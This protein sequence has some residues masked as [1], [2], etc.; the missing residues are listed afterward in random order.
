M[1]ALTTSST[2][3]HDDLL[4]IDVAPLRLLMRMIGGAQLS[5]AIYAVVKLGIPDVCARGP[6]T[7]E[8]LATVCGADAR[9]LGRYLRVLAANRI[10]SE[11][12]KGLYSLTEIGQLLRSDVPGTAAPF[13]ILLPELIEPTADAALYALRTGRSAFVHSHGCGLYEYLAGVPDTEALFAQAMSAR[14]S[15]HHAAVIGAVDWDGVR[16]VVDVGG[17]HGSFLTAI[18]EH[19]PG[20]TGILFDQPHVVA[21]AGPAL[22]EAGVADRVDV[23]PGDFFTAVPP[24]GDLYLVANVLWNWPDDQARGILQRCREA[25]APTARLA[26]CEPVIP[27]GNELHAAKVLDLGN[28]W[29]NGGGTRTPDEWREFLDRAGFELVGITETAVEWSVIEARPATYGGG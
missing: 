21:G 29:L 25:M 20:A 3:V 12:D 18:L 2:L 23:V 16:H 8:E 14:A 10:F 19:L 5:R 6:A 24:G 7:V 11:D 13:A 9:A 1:T 17:N 27:P 15:Q 26:I 22:A 28:F 4:G